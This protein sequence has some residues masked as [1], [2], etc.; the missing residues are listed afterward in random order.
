MKVLP[1]VVLACAGAI[2][3]NLRGAACSRLPTDPL[4]VVSYHT[5]IP[6]AVHI[7]MASLIVI[8]MIPLIVVVANDRKYLHISI[9][10]YWIPARFFPMEECLIN[11]A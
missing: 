2:S 7:L 6:F 9:L 1:Q 11:S 8:L 4:F 10:S 3:L 5:F